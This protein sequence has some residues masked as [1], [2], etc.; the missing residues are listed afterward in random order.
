MLS[1][2]IFCAGMLCLAYKTRGMQENLQ[3]ETEKGKKDSISRCNHVEIYGALNAH[4]LLDITVARSAYDMDKGMS[5][6]MHVH[7]SH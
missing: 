6:R 1:A 5:Y 3:A 2:G 4:Y 7:K